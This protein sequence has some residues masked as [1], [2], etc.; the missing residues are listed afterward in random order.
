MIKK[1]L[2]AIGLLVVVVLLIGFVMPGTTLVTKS[3]TIDAPVNYVFEE[4]DDL[5][6]WTSWS[7]WQRNDSTMKIE[8]GEPTAGHNGNYSW[9]STNG[10][11]RLI[12]TESAPNQTIAIDINFVNMGTGR[13][14]YNFK[15]IGNATNLTVDFSFE[16]GL[17]P[18]TRLMG[19]F[20]LKP[21]IDKAIE[22]ELTA[23]KEIAEAKPKF[24][25]V[26]EV[27]PVEPIIYIGMQHTMSPKDPVA[28]GK[29]MDRMYGEIGSMM[30]KLKL[31][32]IGMPICVYPKFTNESM[33]IV[34]G[35]PIRRPLNNL[36]KKF[37][38]SQTI[39]GLVV[40]ASHSG[41]Y[42]K[43]QET[44]DQII[45]Y[46]A[47]RKLEENGSPWE[48]YATDPGTE[49]DTTKWVTEVYYPIKN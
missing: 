38:V 6:K 26:L 41:S 8:Y 12:I 28:V 17:N 10:S 14:W 1:I 48:V 34:C 16:N 9:T 18:I 40:K 30:K 47:F 24:S 49:P 42:D 27:I 29:E 43:L 31:K 36:N 21:E 20:M 22:N 3:I 13:S 23:L 37:I 5:K 44:H 11:G 32:A 19:A 7:W 2:I 25:V 45:K 4:V 46:I 33:D 39:G 15:Q 35:I